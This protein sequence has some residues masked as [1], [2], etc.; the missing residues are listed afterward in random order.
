MV[1]LSGIKV[2]TAFHAYACLVLIGCF[3][4]N[5]TMKK[6]FFTTLVL[7]LLLLKTQAQFAP[8]VGVIGTTAMH[9]D[10][11]AF[12]TWAKS[13]IISRGWQD[14]S[15]TTLGKAQVGDETYIPGPPG[16]G[17][18][19]L[20]DGG[21]AIITFEKPIKN[22]AGFDFAVF[23]NG[24]IDQTLKPGTAFLE[25]AF[26]EVSSD[27]IK[28]FRFPATSLNDTTTQ[29]DSYEG[30]DATK[31]NNFAG[32]YIANYGTPFDL[33]EL[34]NTQGL[35][36]MNITHVKII[37]V[38]GSVSN[39]YATRDSYGNKVNDPWP[40]PFSQSGFDLD[41]VGVIHQNNNVGLTDVT[42][43]QPQLKVYPNPASTQTNININ[44]DGVND[45]TIDVY[46]QLGKLVKTSNINTV[47]HID[48]PGIYY[49]Q[50]KHNYGIYTKKITVF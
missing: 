6:S 21:A 43:N 39:K 15:D 42:A 9:K 35:D 14:I 48:E 41:A 50:V 1:K 47:L 31:I 8:Q 38:V 20:G 37:D 29:L 32:K 18:V 13:G 12:I 19:S 45:A 26:I 4:L 30:I 44:V 16:N 22:G 28:Y 10:S 46:T 24:F 7:C 40:T 27:G 36:V 34:K 11:S 25:L 5:F 23:E 49:L 2:I 17:I 3:H 33:D